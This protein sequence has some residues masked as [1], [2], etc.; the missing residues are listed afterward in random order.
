[1]SRPV[2]ATWTT[3]EPTGERFGWWWEAHV[4]VESALPPGPVVVYGQRIGASQTL[5][6]WGAKRQADRAIRRHA[7]ARRRRR[8]ITE[9]AGPIIDR[10][11]RLWDSVPV[12]GARDEGGDDGPGF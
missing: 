12:V 11:G 9:D 3:Y 7:S 6:R 4:M 1:M 2:G 8:E 5:T 10:D